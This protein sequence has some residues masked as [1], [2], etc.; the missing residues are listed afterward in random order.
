[1]TTANF[2]ARMV[3]VW[4][5]CGL[6]IT[7]KDS[8]FKLGWL[9]LIILSVIININIITKGHCIETMALHDCEIEYLW[10]TKF[11]PKQS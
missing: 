2:K 10:A 7:M 1:M 3:S 11:Y 4:C 5:E 6:F 8:L 9:N